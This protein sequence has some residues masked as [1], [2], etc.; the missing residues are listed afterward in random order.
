[1]SISDAVSKLKNAK[2][3]KDKRVL[4]IFAILLIIV[5]LAIFAST[6][7]KPAKTTSLQNA[8]TNQTDS[9]SS[10]ALD[11][12][13]QLSKS[14]QTMLSSVNGLDNVKVVVVV[15]SS[16]TTKYLY[17]GQDQ[18]QTVV[19]EKQNSATKPIA[20][21]ELLPKI[22]GILIVAKGANNLSLKNK[23]LNAISTTYSVDISKIDILEG[24]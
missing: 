22:T 15:E 6:F 16:P 13:N 5:A 2:I 19:L 14:L 17:S 20:V 11:Y 18:N 12:S 9:T 21:V 3:F 10:L 23:L 8:I 7:I 4:K 24:K 1:M